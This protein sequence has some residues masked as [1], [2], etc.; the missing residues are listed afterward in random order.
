MVNKYTPTGVI[1]GLQ[2]GL[3]LSIATK[4]VKAALYKDGLNGNTDEYRDWTSVD[5]LILSLVAALFVVFFSSPPNEEAAK[6]ETTALP[7]TSATSPISA[8]GAVE[9]LTPQRNS[10]DKGSDTISTGNV[11]VHVGHDDEGSDSGNSASGLIEG[12]QANDKFVD[13]YFKDFNE[14]LLVDDPTEDHS[15]QDAPPATMKAETT[16]DSRSQ[17]SNSWF[18]CIAD[19]LRGVRMPVALVLTILGVILALAQKSASFWEDAIRVCNLM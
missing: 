17:A 14:T 9:K 10:S 11:H 15:E 4:G 12:E 5:G 6:S 13:H 19:S 2:L 8:K 7:V 1:R 18:M 16:D 3:G